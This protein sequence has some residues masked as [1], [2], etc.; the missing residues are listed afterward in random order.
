M[1]VHVTLIVKMSTHIGVSNA[2]LCS[3]NYIAILLFMGCFE[4]WCLTFKWSFV[5]VSKF[6][7]C[8]IVR[9]PFIGICMRKK[10]SHLVQICSV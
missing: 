2:G 9:S 6:N 3:V 1:T 8:A 7:C 4:S 10:I 5:C